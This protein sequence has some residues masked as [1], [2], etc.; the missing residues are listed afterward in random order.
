MRNIGRSIR[1]SAFPIAGITLV[2]C[3]PFF[4]DELWQ[5]A[6]RPHVVQADLRQSIGYYENAVTAINDRRYGLALEYLQ[7]A[8][9]QKPDDVRVL[10]AFGVVYDK[11][12][13]FDLSARYYA[14][15]ASLDPKSRIVA[16]D[17]DY[18][19]KLQGIS[20]SGLAAVAANAEP[21]H[22]QE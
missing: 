6:Q 3:A 16:A 10:T 20:S 14:Q 13:R 18:S 19:R 5:P 11:L 21:N 7:A 12:G 17:M 9:N 22:D 2:A 15:A 1:N 8:R 4:G